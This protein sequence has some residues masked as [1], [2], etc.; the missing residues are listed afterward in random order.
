MKQAG[1]TPFSAF[2]TT[3]KPTDL[4]GYENHRYMSDWWTADWGDPQLDL[5]HQ[6][7]RVLAGRQV[8]GM[9]VCSTSDYG[10]SSGTLMT[11]NFM[12]HGTLAQRIRLADYRPFLMTLYG[13]LCF[14]MD[15]GSRYAPEDALLPG[16]YPGEGDPAFSSAVVNSELQP[17]M[18]LRWLLCYE[19]HDQDI[20][21]LQKAA[22][23]HWFAA[24]QRIVVENC[25]TR[26]GAISWTCEASSITD[27]KGWTLTVALTPSQA[28]TAQIVI[29]L[30]P[31][32]GRNLRT[33]TSG[34]I[35]GNTIVISA[36]ALTGVNLLSIQVT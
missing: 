3:R 11:A 34:Q 18:A 28:A 1:I 7:H 29:H 21:H 32:D 31:S 36:S 26:F 17:A 14:A 30:H 9:N 27:E 22:P 5:G 35:M 33:T 6:R 23:K 20:V 12:E 2:D 4:T 25:P 16:S 8:L 10:A 24:G 15:C 13:N 19:E